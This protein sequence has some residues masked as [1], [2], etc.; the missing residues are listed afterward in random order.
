MLPV[1]KPLPLFAAVSSVT[2]VVVENHGDLSG[3]RSH[4][5]DDGGLGDMGDFIC[6]SHDHSKDLGGWCSAADCI[7][8]ASL[9]NWWGR[10]YWSDKVFVGA[11]VLV[12]VASSSC[13]FLWPYNYNFVNIIVRNALNNNLSIN[14]IIRRTFNLGELKLLEGRNKLVY[15]TK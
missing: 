5:N 2:G 14:Y 10:R 3:C 1:I 11:V 6:W 8:C 7:E 12:A 15:L 9:W 4:D 13:S